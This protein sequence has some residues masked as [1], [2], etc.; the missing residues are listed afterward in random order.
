MTLEAKNTLREL[1]RKYFDDHIE[2]AIWSA[3]KKLL[4]IRMNTNDTF[5]FEGATAKDI[6]NTLVRGSMS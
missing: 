5:K 1:N 3:E 2:E 4:T 6:Y